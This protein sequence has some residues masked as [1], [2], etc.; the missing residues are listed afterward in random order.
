MLDLQAQHKATILVIDDAPDNLVLI[1]NLLKDLY[2]VK[3]ATSGE[4]GLKIA[5]SNAPLDLIL[6]DVMMPE[7][8]GYEVCKLLKENLFTRDIPV[9][10][11]TAKSEVEDEQQGLDLGAVDYITKPFSPPIVLA[12]VRN[13]LALKAATDYF[14]DKYDL[15]ESAVLANFNK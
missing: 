3:V 4:R 13:H 8:D 10:F 9:I 7:M 6:L 15:L 1:S 12:R 11:L 14:R 2:K 5:R